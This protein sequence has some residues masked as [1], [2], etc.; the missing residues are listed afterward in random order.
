MS[1]RALSGR[2]TRLLGMP[3]GR[4]GWWGPVLAIG[5]LVALCA[6]FTGGLA[7]YRIAD[8]AHFNAREVVGQAGVDY[9]AASGLA[10]L[11]PAFLAFGFLVIV[12]WAFVRRRVSDTWRELPT[13]LSVMV[14]A[15]TAARCTVLWFKPAEPDVARIALDTRAS[16]C[17]RVVL[18]TGERLYLDVKT[19][20]AGEE[21][22]A[23]S[24]TTIPSSRVVAVS[25]PPRTDC[26]G[27][28]SIDRLAGE[29]PARP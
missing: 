25:I 19:R 6:A 26:T 27:G 5:P 23:P 16:F 13:W 8:N 15:T 21:E 3:N 7:L 10:L 11:G 2:L 28:V 20:R 14:V 1:V 12:V 9:I 17:A 22:G 24:A 29:V 4:V 18:E